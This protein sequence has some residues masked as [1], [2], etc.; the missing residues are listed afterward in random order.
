M[1]NILFMLI[2]KKV[3]K[4]MKKKVKSHQHIENLK[5]IKLVFKIPN[6]L[7]KLININLY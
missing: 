6:T 7:N 4:I 3:I 5:F 1:K 2:I